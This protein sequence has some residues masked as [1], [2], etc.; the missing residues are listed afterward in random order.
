MS[1]KKQPPER[2]YLQ[3]YDTDELENEIYATWC[4]HR[5]NDNDVEYKIVKKRERK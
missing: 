3:W 2:I 5:V 1:D 4:E